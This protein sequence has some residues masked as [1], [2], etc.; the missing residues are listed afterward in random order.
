MKLMKALQVVRPRTFSLVHVPVPD[1]ET[2]DPNT[3]LVQPE[4]VSLCGSDIPFFTGSKRFKRFPLPPGAP[5][6]ECVGQVIKSTSSLFRPGERVVA[7]PERDQG[8][9][10]FFIARAAKAV[11]LPDGLND[12][13]TSCLIQPL[14]TVMNG[15][16]RLGS[17]EGK[18]VAIVGLGSIGLFFCWLLKQRGAAQITGIDPLEQ[19]C[20]HAEALGVDRTYAQRSIEVVHDFL[21]GTGKWNPPDI[22]IEAV[23]HQMDTLNDCLELVCQRGT[24]LAFGVPD[25]AVYAI[26]YE[27]FFRKNAHLVAAVSPEWGEYMVKARD[28]F[29]ENRN[30][31]ERLVTHRLSVQEAA[32]AFTLYE[33]H[34]DGILKVL[35]DATYW[36][37]RDG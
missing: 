19:R 35:M 1:L 26:E 4:W 25:H 27:T 30:V 13:G 11:K 9:A 24:V 5:A 3:I 21:E 16:D 20:R 23:G 22:C 10:E 37:S 33:R 2:T 28:V 7:I 15:I 31:L 8:L 36:Q 34:E 12:Q 14:S 18:S 32:K 6:H 17:V 29:I